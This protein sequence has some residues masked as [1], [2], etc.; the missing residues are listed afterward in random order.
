MERRPLG[1]TGL[2]GSSFCFSTW[3]IGGAY[4]G[5]VDAEDAVR[6]LRRALDLG[7]TVYDLSDVYG[8]GRSEVIVGEA[9]RGRRSEVVLVTKAGYLPG[10]DGAQKLFARQP[11]YFEMEYLE[12]ACT[13]SLRRLQT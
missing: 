7:V 9:F 3:E 10:I 5:P 13:M 8:N 11:Q 4:W 6:L 12:Q 1:R 2:Q